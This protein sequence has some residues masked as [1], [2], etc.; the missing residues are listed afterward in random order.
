MQISIGP[1]I[2]ERTIGIN[3]LNTPI[4]HGG[5]GRIGQIV[6]PIPLRKLDSSGRN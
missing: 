4:G 3:I 5:F 2:R 1:K 6:G